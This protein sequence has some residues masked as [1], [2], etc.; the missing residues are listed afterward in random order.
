MEKNRD[1]LE[2]AAA[3][4][5]E[6]K[7]IRRLQLVVDLTTSALY[8]DSNMSLEEARRMVRGAERAVLNLFPDK[9]STFD[10]VLLPRF[11]RILYERWGEGLDGT[12]H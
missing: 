9:Q 12:V 7:N 3:I 5:Q 1:E 8:Q 11:E 4:Q 6:K 10:I 2:R